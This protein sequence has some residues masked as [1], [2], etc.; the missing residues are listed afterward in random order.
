MFIHTQKHFQHT[1][2]KM[3]SD[4]DDVEI[5][6]A[7]SADKEELQEQWWNS[8]M[9]CSNGVSSLTEMHT[10]SQN[11]IRNTQ[12]G[13]QTLQMSACSR[14]SLSWSLSFVRK[15]WSEFSFSTSSTWMILLQTFGESQLVRYAIQ[16]L[17]A[18]QWPMCMTKSC[19]RQARFYSFRAEH[20]FAKK[21]EPA[22][23]ISQGRLSGVL[24][25]CNF[26]VID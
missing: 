24:S 11:E 5:W 15:A 25:F 1:T 12:T 2:H 26:D 18:N 4:V 21:W 9:Q 16:L 13:L 19:C 17:F 8:I 20:A 14:S 3:S 7:F 23:S 10:S 6:Y 22:E